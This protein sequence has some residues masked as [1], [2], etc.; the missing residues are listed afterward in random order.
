MTK[1]QPKTINVSEKS[2]LLSK[3]PLSIFENA[4]KHFKTIK[5]YCIKI[6]H[7]KLN[8]SRSVA[9]KNFT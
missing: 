9:F 4:V 1:T 7:S 3:I 2:S 8:Y 5:I 6:E